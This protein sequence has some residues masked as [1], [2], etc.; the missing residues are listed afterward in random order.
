[1]IDK[2]LPEIKSHHKRVISIKYILRILLEM[3]GLPYKNIK[4]TAYKKVKD[5]IQK[6]IT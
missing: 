3:L 5:D 6:V 1:M 2:V 4:K